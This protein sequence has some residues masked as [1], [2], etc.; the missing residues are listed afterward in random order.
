MHEICGILAVCLGIW[1]SDAD[2]GFSNDLQRHSPTNDL[3][4][5]FMFTVYAMVS[6][7]KKRE[8]EKLHSR[9]NS[10]DSPLNCWVSRVCLHH[11]RSDRVFPWINWILVISVMPLA[12][13]AVPHIPP[14]HPI[15]TQRHVIP[16]SLRLSIF[17]VTRSRDGN[18]KFGSNRSPVLVDRD[19]VG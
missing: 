14:G 7:T 10:N 12:A 16:F 19:R 11:Y 3:Q 13:V 15:R 2:D 6:Q 18:N 9:E 5:R 17:C 1:W 8:L 4:H